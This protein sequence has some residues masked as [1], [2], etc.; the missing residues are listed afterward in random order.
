MEYITNTV[1]YVNN[2]IWESYIKPWVI[3][4]LAVLFI[5]WLYFF[6][7]MKMWNLSQNAEKKITYQYDNIFYLWSLY[8]NKHTDKLSTNP[9]VIVLK[10]IWWSGKSKYIPNRQLIQDTISKIESKIWVQVIP[11][12]EWKTLSR[13][14]GKYK[15]R[16]FFSVLLKT[17]IVLIIIFLVVILFCVIFWKANW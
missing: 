17:I 14:Y 10:S 1:D 3:V 12:S 16:K 8:Y 11:N 7:S 5:V 15:I 4:L 6:L 2:L 13:L 9:W